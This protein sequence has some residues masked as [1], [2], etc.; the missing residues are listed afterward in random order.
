MTAYGAQAP[1]DKQQGETHARPALLSRGSLPHVAVFVLDPGEAMWL[2][3]SGC[4]LIAIKASIIAP[5]VAARSA[6]DH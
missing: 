2:A 5:M 1:T 6:G 4:H 3:S